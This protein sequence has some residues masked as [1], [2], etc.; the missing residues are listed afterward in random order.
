MDLTDVERERDASR[1][2][3]GRGG[4]EGKAVQTTNNYTG[5]S[6]RV[7]TLKAVQT[8]MRQSLLFLNILSL[9]IIHRN[10]FTFALI[11]EYEYITHQKSKT[12]RRES[13]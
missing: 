7:N 5:H 3:T 2:R 10:E 9:L 12:F 6:L 11:F 13:Y 4:I 1:S 8:G